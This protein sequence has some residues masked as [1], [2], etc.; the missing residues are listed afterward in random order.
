MKPDYC[1]MGQSIKVYQNRPGMTNNLDKKQGSN[2]IS[3]H[4]F[5]YI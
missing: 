5:W 1:Q 4:I 3:F 2:N